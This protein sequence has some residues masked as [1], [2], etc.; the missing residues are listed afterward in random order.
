MG[1]CNAQEKLYHIKVAIY[2]T[3]ATDALSH[4][5]IFWFELL[6][7][8]SYQTNM[9]LHTHM[10]SI[11]VEWLCTLQPTTFYLLAWRRMSA[12]AK[13]RLWSVDKTIG[14][15][16]EPNTDVYAYRCIHSYIQ[17]YAWSEF[18]K[19]DLYTLKKFKI[20]YV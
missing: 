16:C 1:S 11:G 12:S 15:Q 9:F 8:C 19:T 5:H 17:Y 4:C 14:L 18:W 2:I 6:Y 10:Y 13:I 20:P 7:V 3:L